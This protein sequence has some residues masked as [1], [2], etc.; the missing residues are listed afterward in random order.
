MDL[1]KIMVN[2]YMYFLNAVSTREL[3]VVYML[4]Y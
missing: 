3:Y 1:K 2:A 4:F